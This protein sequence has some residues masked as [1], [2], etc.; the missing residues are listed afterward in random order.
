LTAPQRPQ[1]PVGLD[2]EWEA[3]FSEA[4][5]RLGP[6]TRTVL[7]DLLPDDWSFEGRRVLDFGCGP[8]RTLRH[9]LP[10]AETAEF[11]GTDI[12]GPSI[13]SVKAELCPPMH[14]LRCEPSPPL[15]LEYGSFDLCW[16]ISVFTHLADNSLPWLVELHRLLEP[17]GLLIATYIG[18]WHS[19]L[20]TGEPWDEDAVGMNVIRHNQDPALGGPRAL[21]SDWWIREHW[22]RAFDVLEL[23]PRIHNQSWAVLR[24]RDIEV[25]PEELE[26]PSDDPREYLA[27]RHNLR[28]AQQEIELTQ[29]QQAARLDELRREYEQS[30]SWRLTRPLREARRMIRSYRSRRSG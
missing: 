7:I 28:Q 5:Q 13:E 18:R 25:T 20:L 12:D 29:R 24:K 17:G 26:R 16:A 2:T 27:M 22:G 4:F 1:T 8:G 30:L 9:F 10:E 6:E 15:G 11:W 23:A 3:T 19:E 14:A 21:M